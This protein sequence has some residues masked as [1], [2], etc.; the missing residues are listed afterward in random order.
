MAPDLAGD[1]IDEFLGLLTAVTAAAYKPELAELRGNGETLCLR[2]AEPSLP[3]WL[4]T[5][6]P[7]DR[8]GSTDR[9][10]PT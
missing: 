4:I 7:E 10:T 3:G 9:R 1:A 2:P 5:R 8:S 6:T